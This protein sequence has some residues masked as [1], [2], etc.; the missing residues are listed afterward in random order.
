MD[1]NVLQGEFDHNM[2]QRFRVTCDGENLFVRHRARVIAE[3]FP[4]ARDRD[5]FRLLVRTIRYVHGV[6][7]N[8]SRD[9]SCWMDS[10]LRRVDVS[11]TRR[12][13]CGPGAGI[14]DR[15]SRQNLPADKPGGDHAAF[16]LDRPVNEQIKR[17]CVF[18]VK[19]TAKGL[20]HLYGCLG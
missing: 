2:R 12:C 11:S 15:C 19:R 16:L 13:G 10:A 1:A 14:E 4:T 9:D 3:R 20:V 7:L 8:A 6:P 18:G 17:P 5:R